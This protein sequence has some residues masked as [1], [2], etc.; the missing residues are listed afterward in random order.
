VLPHWLPALGQATWDR[1]LLGLTDNQPL[2]AMPEL[3]GLL[4]QAAQTNAALKAHLRAQTDEAMALGLFG[5]P[6]FV[7]ADGELFWGND[8]LDQAVQWPWPLKSAHL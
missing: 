8:R 7:T 3:A 2:P 6:S 5:A 1:T 4:V